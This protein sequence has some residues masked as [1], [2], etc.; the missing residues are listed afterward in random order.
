MSEGQ[1]FF[2]NLELNSLILIQSFLLDEGTILKFVEHYLK[3]DQML[4]SI[5]PYQIKSSLVFLN[6]LIRSTLPRLGSVVL[7]LIGEYS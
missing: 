5:G 4:I 2:N 6:T 7:D 1:P 3:F